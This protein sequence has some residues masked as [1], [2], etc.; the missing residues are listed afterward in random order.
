[1]KRNLKSLAIEA[2]T[3]AAFE[4]EVID[5]DIPVIVDFWAAWCAPCRMVAPTIDAIAQDK[6]A[7]LKV[8]KVNVDKNRDAAYKY[9]I[10]SIPTIALFKAGE[11]VA[12]SVGAKPRRML[13]ADLKI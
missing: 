1:M 2:D 7:Q 5:C 3:W 9:K 8:V 12:S 13:E 4:R 11:M 10:A 6:G